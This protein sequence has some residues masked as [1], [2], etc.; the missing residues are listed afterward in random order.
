MERAA[1]CL[2]ACPDHF[3]GRDRDPRRGPVLRLRV[4]L[5]QPAGELGCALP[6]DLWHL[7]PGE[8]TDRMRNL[9][10]PL[11]VTCVDAFEVRRKHPVRILKTW[12]VKPFALLHCRFRECCCW[13]PTTCR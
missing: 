5:H 11:D 6:I 9:L 8:M 4:G 10:E 3:E 2:P 7:G 13:M 12:E 1:A